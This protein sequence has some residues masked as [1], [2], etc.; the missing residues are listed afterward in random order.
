MKLRMSERKKT[1][2][3]YTIEERR[4]REGEIERKRK[5][6]IEK[7]GNHRNENNG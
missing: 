2:S 1:K 7:A 4:D 3:I 6:D 5:K